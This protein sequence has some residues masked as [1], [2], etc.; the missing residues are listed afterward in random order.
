M[1]GSA[2]AC[3]PARWD[4]SFTALTLG[5]IKVLTSRVPSEAK[6]GSARSAKGRAGAACSSLEQE[7]RAMTQRWRVTRARVTKVEGAE[8]EAWGRQ[9][10][11]G[12]GRAGAAPGHTHDIPALPG[13][14]GD[15]YLTAWLFIPSAL[16]GHKTRIASPAPGSA[17]TQWDLG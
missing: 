2:Q 6:A 12:A 15:V 10:H 14:K 11:A 7:I 3:C 5:R 13:N 4:V 17:P 9:S 16:S 8:A 1:W